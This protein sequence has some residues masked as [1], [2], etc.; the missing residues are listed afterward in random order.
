LGGEDDGRILLDRNLRHRL[1]CA[2]LQRYR[3]L[4]DDVGGLAELYRRLILALGGDD[5]GA[6]LALG[7]GFLGHRPLHVLRQRDVLDLDR[8]NLGAPRLG[9]LVDHVLDL[10]VDARG[11]G[12]QLIE[13]EPS[14]HIA[15]RGL[16]DLV[17]GVVNVLDGDDRLFRIGNVIIGDRRDIDR[18]VVLGNDLLRRD[19]HGDGAQRDAHHLLDRNKDQRQ[20]GPAHP[21]KLAQQEH[22]AALVLLQHAKRNQGIERQQNDNKKDQVHGVLIGCLDGS[23]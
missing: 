10:V 3:V 12:E 19:L 9:V 2:Q 13:A 8:G 1:Q 7:L 16:A 17:D 20:P 14:D 6:A 15:H 21:R 4:R 18:D 23:S 11:I 5:L 22:H